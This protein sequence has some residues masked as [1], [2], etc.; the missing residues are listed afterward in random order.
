MFYV[1][2]NS[3]PVISYLKKANKNGNMLRKEVSVM[4]LGKRLKRLR[5][6]RGLTQKELADSL[7]VTFQTVSKWE[8]DENEPDIATLKRIAKLYGISLDYLLGDEDDKLVKVVEKNPSAPNYEEVVSNTSSETGNEHYIEKEV[9]KPVYINKTIIV[10]NTAHVCERCKK[11][12][13]QD[14]L[15]MEHQLVNHGSRTSSATYK[16]VYFHKACFEEEKKEREARE[17]DREARKARHSKKLLFGVSIPVGVA[18]MIISMICLIAIPQCAAIFNTVAAVFIS[19]GVGYA[20]FA[21]LYCILSISY[22]SW[23]FGSIARYSIHF[24][25]ILFSF[26]PE[27]FAWL[28]AAKIAFFVLGIAVTVGMFALAIVITAILSIVS[29]PFILG[30]NIRN[31]YQEAL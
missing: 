15:V 6:S 22:I 27:G 2:G 17:K 30:M 8:N 20:M 13:L 4:T 25:M 10:T 16:D 29:F 24:P 26:S 23:V 3:I 5:T 19:I 31:N 7:H 18:S 14:D 21:D 1:S 28:I 9:V 11:D 12:I